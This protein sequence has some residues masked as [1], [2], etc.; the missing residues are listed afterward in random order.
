MKIKDQQKLEKHLQS[1]IQ[2]FFDAKAMQDLA[3]DRS[4]FQE[5]INA[6]EVY[7]IE[8]LARTN[9]SPN[10]QDHEYEE[11]HANYESSKKRQLSRWII[12]GEPLIPTFVGITDDKES[13]WLIWYLFNNNSAHITLDVRAK[14]GEPIHLQLKISEIFANKIELLDLYEE[15]LKSK[16]VMQVN[17]S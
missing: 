13:S 3:I 4:L 1:I 2:N 8:I 5:Q 16:D 10:M 6:K 7:E 9:K 17:Q 12:D 11:A 15:Y 14:I